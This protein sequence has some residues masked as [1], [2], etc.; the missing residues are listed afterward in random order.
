MA[1][2]D[3]RTKW[4]YF[5][6]AGQTEGRADMKNL[7][8]GK[9]AN[10]AEMA[11]L[12][13]EVPPGFTITTE[14]CNEFYRR[15]K[16]WPEGL[17][18]QVKENLRKLEQAMGRRFGDPNNPLLVSVRSGARVSMP[19]MMDTVLNLGLNDVTVQGL[20][21]QSNNERF[22]YDSYRRFIQ[23]YGDVV[24]GVP[25]HLFEERLEAKKKARGVTEDPQLTAQD[26]KE[27]VE[28]FK[29]IVRQ[30]KGQDFPSDPWEQLRGAIN[31][32]FNSWNNPRAIKYREIHNI[33][34]DWGTA[35]NVQA[36][37]FGNMG[38]DSGTGV[39]FT[40]NPSTGAKEF[41]GE[42][43]INAQGEDVVAGIRTPLPVAVLK[44]K[45]PHVYAQLEE[46]NK[47]LEA[48]YR[49]MLD[50][51]FTV[52]Q[53]KLYML[54]C[55]VGKRTAMAAVRIAVEMAQ[56]GLIDRQTA[57]LRVAPEQIDQLLH[58]TI[59]PN[60]KVEPVAK[61]LPA[62]PGAAVGQLAFFAD[63]AERM[64]DEGK[65]VVLIRAETSPEDIGGMYKAQGILTSRGGMTSHAAVVARGMG[66]PCVVGCG[67]LDIDEKRKVVRI[68][69]KEL[70]EGDWVTIDGSTGNVYI[71][72]VPLVQPELSGYFATL[73][74]WADEF[75]ALG[76][77]ANAD[78]PADARTARQFGAQGIGLCRTE[79]MFFGEGRIVPMREMILADTKEERERALA[80]LL[81]LQRG[82]FYEIF[83]EMMGYPVVIRLLDPPL[84]EFLP[85]EPDA[86]AEVAKQMGVRPEV[87]E[88]RVRALAE[89]NPMLGLRGC[90][91]G[92]VYPEIYEMQTRAIFEAAC[93]LAKEGH[94]IEP[95]VM[96]PLVGTPG[97]LAFLKE[98]CKKVAEQV[99]AEQGVRVP[100]RIGTMVEVPRAALVADE[101]AKEAQFFSF[102][103][104]DLTQMTLGF[105]RDDVGKYVPTYVEMGLLKADP[106]QTLDVEGVGQLVKMGVERGKQA[107][108]DLV[109]GICGEHGG[110]PASIWFFHEAGLDYVSCSPY[111]VPV[112]RLAAAQANLSK[113]RTG[114][115]GRAVEA[116]ASV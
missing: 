23:M 18:E 9:G 104:N 95:E 6:G 69:G 73:L 4:V 60:A 97:E 43:L 16:Q 13:I 105:S 52:Q 71:G 38:E 59:D 80:K 37:V 56:E 7:L 113:P 14:A 21:R 106:F 41:Y 89:A 15:G 49:D 51:E 46:I 8:G 32:V 88:S 115:K 96:I 62:S 39:A 28:E 83:K 107:N 31:A 103:T 11:N 40:R 34:G 54:Q 57:V 55:R 91:L 44:E 100:Y 1:S 35:V 90:R 5:F 27:L 25:R 93:Q 99:M 116:H 70:R 75:R 66:K 94:E 10:L 98:R 77:R 67:A 112:A 85:K 81:P 63:D 84:H 20:A 24:L 53:G 42:I 87:I 2:V 108:P 74:E 3:G 68:N 47:K 79:H 102:G 33:P 45:M 72:Q 12:G 101:I 64:A 82:D 114:G 61:G 92:I 111:R 65:K 17:E 30:Q 22:A 86:V 48:A 110:D 36:M 109:V 29:E 50:I 58:P 19:G 78:T 26:L 76:V